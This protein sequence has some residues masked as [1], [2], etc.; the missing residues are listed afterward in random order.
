M[1][2]LSKV[3]QVSMCIRRS[4][5][6]LS[7]WVDVLTSFSGK[8]KDRFRSYVVLLDARSYFPNIRFNVFD[9]LKLYVMLLYFDSI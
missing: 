7:T 5:I 4:F 1:R 8:Y 9:T 2:P 6:V 3:K